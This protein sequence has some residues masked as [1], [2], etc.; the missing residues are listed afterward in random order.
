MEH[1]LKPI[2]EFKDANPLRVKFFGFSSLEQ[3][4]V[5]FFYNCRGDEV[6]TTSQLQSQC[7]YLNS[8]SNE[9]IQ[10]NHMQDNAITDSDRYA[11]EVPLYLAAAQDAHILL[12]SDSAYDN[13]Q[14]GYEIGQLLNGE[15]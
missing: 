14:T 9:Y 12:A 11:F 6:Y 15:E 2:I 13:I 4:S 1:T 3:S 8:S 10:L 5:R 7:Q